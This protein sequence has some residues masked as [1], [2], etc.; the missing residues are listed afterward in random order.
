MAFGNA[1]LAGSRHIPEM[2]CLA[3]CGRD[4]APIR[5]PGDHHYSLRVIQGGQHASEDGYCV[6]HSDGPGHLCNE[7]STKNPLTEEL[8]GADIERELVD[9]AE[10]AERLGHALDAQQG[11]LGRSRFRQWLGRLRARFA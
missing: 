10:I 7:R 9:R 11:H 3:A 2:N 6:R 8:A 4:P 1:D 5:M